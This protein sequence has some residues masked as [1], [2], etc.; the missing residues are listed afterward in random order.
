MK[1]LICFLIAILMLSAFGG[2]ALA[3]TPENGISS[4]A[5]SPIFAPV[6]AAR[7]DG[8]RT[9]AVQDGFTVKY[10]DSEFETLGEVRLFAES[11][12][13]IPAECVFSNSGIFMGRKT[14]AG[15]GTA[16]CF[17]GGEWKLFG[18]AFFDR[19]GKLIRELPYIKVIY[20]EKDFL[21][22]ETSSGENFKIKDCELKINRVR[23]IGEDEIAIFCDEHVFYYRISEDKIYLSFD[24]FMSNENLGNCIANGEAL[25][26]GSAF[27]VCA[28]F[29][30]AEEKTFIFCSKNQ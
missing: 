9:L 13:N 16:V 27:A 29:Y 3:E 19:S 2:E 17:V 5:E 22:A 1:K 12:G 26:K 10:L 4:A 25:P 15:M 28:V 30:D 20:D 14:E 11:F 23:W 18:G 6:K 24:F 7:L 21:T 8:G